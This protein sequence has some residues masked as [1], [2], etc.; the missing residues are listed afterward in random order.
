MNITTALASALALIC[1]AQPQGIT[2]QLD[3]PIPAA[4]HRAAGNVRPT[5]PKPVYKWHLPPLTQDQWLIAASA[6]GECRGHGQICMTATIAVMQNRAKRYGTTIAV[7]SMKRAQLSCWNAG[8]PNRVAMYGIGRW[9][10]PKSPDG[11]AWIMARGLAIE[12]SHGHLRDVTRGAL[13][14]HSKAV[15]PVWDKAMRLVATIGGQDYFVRKAA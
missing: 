15:H 1:P 7:E 5:K 6:W 12:A 2:V 14:Y 3:D 10:N 8:D 4:S 9:L 11:I 13:W